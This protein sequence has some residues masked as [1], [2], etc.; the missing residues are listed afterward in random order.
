ML[1]VYLCA[2][3]FHIQLHLALWWAS[4]AMVFMY[5][6]I[7]ELNR[8]VEERLL[9]SLFLLSFSVANAQRYVIVWRF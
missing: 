6:S 2:I 4:L 8:S 9:G 5:L 1:T 3:V 7:I